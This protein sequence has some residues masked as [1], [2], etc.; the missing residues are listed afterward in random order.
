ML[1]FAQLKLMQQSTYT[2]RT[3][4]T[5]RFTNTWAVLKVY[6]K[7][8]WAHPDFPANFEHWFHEGTSIFEQIVWFVSS[9]DLLKM[10]SGTRETYAEDCSTKTNATKLDFI[11]S[12]NPCEFLHTSAHFMFSISS[13]FHMLRVKMFNSLAFLVTFSALAEHNINNHELHISIC[14]SNKS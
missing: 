10:C 6:P 12:I 3:T 2:F 13:N 9:M 4:E 11:L 5:I 14:L 7:L 8:S 1:K